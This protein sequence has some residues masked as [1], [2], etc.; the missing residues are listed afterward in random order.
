MVVAAL[1]GK[2]EVLAQ[3]WLSSLPC[4]ETPSS[5]YRREMEDKALVPM[6]EALGVQQLQF[7]PQPPPLFLLLPEAAEVVVAPQRRIQLA[8]LAVSRAPIIAEELGVEGRVGAPPVV[9]AA[10]QTLRRGL[11]GPRARLVVALVLLLREVALTAH[12]VLVA[13]LVGPP[14]TVKLVPRRTEELS[15]EL[16]QRL[17]VEN[18]LV[19]LPVAEQE[20]EGIMAEAAVAAELVAEQEVAV[21]P[22]TL[23]LQ[24]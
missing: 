1:A 17:L 8:V 9:G 6:E 3:S 24:P 12:R 16:M 4:K 10:G 18:E 23:Q 20:A 21:D 2:P 13:H 14:P 22:L 11:P 15:P 7:S 19:Q 5:P